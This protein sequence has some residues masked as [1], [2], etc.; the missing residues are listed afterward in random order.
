MHRRC[1]GDWK[2][3][4]D[5]DLGKKRELIAE[6]SDEKQDQCNLGSSRLRN[7]RLQ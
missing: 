2:G 1:L 4:N 7:G 3:R 6:D 5:G